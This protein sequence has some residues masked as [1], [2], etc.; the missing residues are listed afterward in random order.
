[1]SSTVE[2]ST[3][4]NAFGGV[5]ARLTGVN[6]GLVLLALVT[7]PVQARVLGPDGRGELA[8]I[9]TVLVLA[10]LILDFGLADF[11][12]RERARGAAAGRTLGTAVPL[13]L[14]FSLL[15]V[16]LAWPLGE[17]LGQG[18]EVVERFVRLSLLLMPLFV[19]GWMV[20]GVARGA[21]RFEIIRRWQLIGAAG[22]GLVILGLAAVGRLTV[23][24]AVVATIVM[25]VTALVVSLPVL[26]GTGRWRF[27][28]RVVRP[29]LGFGA[30]SWILAVSSTA[31]HRLDQAVMAA[32]VTSAELGRYAV[33]AGL[34]A[35]AS[36]FVGAVVTALLPRVARE[37]I[38][39]VPRIVRV[40][41]LVM[42]GALA[43]LTASAP[44]AVPLLFGSDFKGAVPLVAILAVATVFMGV[45][46]VAG[47]ALQGHGRPQDS[48]RP[49]LAGLIITIV[50]LALVLDP[51][52]AAGAALV[53]CA[54]YAAVLFGT[55]RAARREF[56][57]SV[58]ELLVPRR[59]DVRWLLSRVRDRS[60]RAA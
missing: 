43:A 52:G 51:L 13:A 55:I 16:L 54:A 20:L 4:A 1:V 7:G 6:G 44:F 27:D 59:A 38:Q 8:A 41:V 58:A 36:G 30:R 42:A 53:S 47:S 12:T 15:G 10:P 24:S 2:T 56:K 39:S 22:S 9:I 28:R 29:A 14:G 21:Q 5:V 37:G 50:G 34:V 26:R 33:A 35:I 57:T 32:V 48:A 17:L 11:V 3:E 45:S 49:Q 18:R 31:N 25:S 46:A 60:G 40:S 19:F 23:T